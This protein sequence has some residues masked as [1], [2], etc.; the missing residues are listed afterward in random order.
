MFL[1]D[2]TCCI[3]WDPQCIKSLQM[4]KH[5]INSSNALVTKLSLVTEVIDALHGFFFFCRCASVYCNVFFLLLSSPS[6]PPPLIYLT[7]YATFFFQ[8]KRQ[9]PRKNNNNNSN[10]KLWNQT[11]SCLP[12]GNTILFSA[13]IFFL[14]LSIH[15]LLSLPDEGNICSSKALVYFVILSSFVMYLW[16]Q[17]FRI[18]F[19][20]VIYV[21]GAESSH[22]FYWPQRFWIKSV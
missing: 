9:N 1:V 8:I 3:D 16:V 4:C 15:L 19:R 5:Y 18:L 17:F 13:S 11:F 22:S 10:K 2:K 12:F 7:T 6:P 20:R 21:K 14:L